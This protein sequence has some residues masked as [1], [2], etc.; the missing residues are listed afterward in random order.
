MQTKCSFNSNEISELLDHNYVCA[1]TV[2]FEMFCVTFL[3]EGYG[4][5]G[6][7]QLLNH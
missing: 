6:I 3:A 4:K 2:L 5:F 1:F 7:A